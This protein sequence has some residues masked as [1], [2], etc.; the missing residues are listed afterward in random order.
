VGPGHVHNATS[1][2]LAET[3]YPVT[4]RD[5]I[6]GRFE[7]VDK[8]ELSVEGTHVVLAWIAV[9][10]HD[11]GTFHGL[12]TGLG[13]TVTTYR[14]PIELKPAYGDRPWGVNVYLRVRIKP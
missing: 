10:T 4:R 7:V 6:T 11:I 13:A 1:S 2:F 9:Y 3:L 5:F 14:V 8:N 12:E